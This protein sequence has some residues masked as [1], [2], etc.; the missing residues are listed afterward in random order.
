MSASRDSSHVAK[1]LVMQ[2][3]SYRLV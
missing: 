2:A 1:V 3:E